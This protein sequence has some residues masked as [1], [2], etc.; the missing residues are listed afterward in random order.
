M[1]DGVGSTWGLISKLPGTYGP[2]NE[3]VN[4]SCFSYNGQTLLPD[5]NS[6]CDPILSVPAANLQSIDTYLYPNPGTGLYRLNLPPAFA[7]SVIRVYN[8]F[9]QLQ[10]EYSGNFQTLDIT[11]FSDGIYYI[12]I[13][14]GQQERMSG[15]I[16]KRD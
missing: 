14:N 2:M 9:G 15:K 3:T 11:A 8:I 7:S 6:P 16:V 13:S 5:T 4:L 10:G 12:T 1:I